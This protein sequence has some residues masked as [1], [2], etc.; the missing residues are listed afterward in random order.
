MNASYVSSPSLRQ[1]HLCEEMAA[2]LSGYYEA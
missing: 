1:L 2:R